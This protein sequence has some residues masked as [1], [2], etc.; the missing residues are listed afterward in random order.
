MIAKKQ[1]TKDNGKGRNM[2]PQALPNWESLLGLCPQ[3]R[4][5]E[6]EALSGFTV[7]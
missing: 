3:I 7:I 6:T 5:S 1:Q 4:N 2:T